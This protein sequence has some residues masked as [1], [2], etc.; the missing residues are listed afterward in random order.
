MSLAAYKR[1]AQ[2]TETPRHTEARLLGDVCAELRAVQQDPSDMKRLR[3]ALDWNRRVWMTLTFDCASPDN[4]LP[5]ALR[6]KIVSLGIWVSRYTEDAMWNNAVIS[7]LIE[8]NEA[9]IL[10]LVARSAEAA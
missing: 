6:A 10:G 5:P 3:E 4:P 7:P 1:T 8:V 9:L 2:F